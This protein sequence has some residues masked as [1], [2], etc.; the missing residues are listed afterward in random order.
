[1]KTNVLEKN[2]AFF[3]SELQSDIKRVAATKDE[4]IDAISAW[5]RGID[6]IESLSDSERWVPVSQKTGVLLDDLQKIVA[7]V[8][9]ITSRCAENDVRLADFLEDLKEIGVFGPEP[10][11]QEAAKNKLLALGKPLE[12]LLQKLVIKSS[13]ELPLLHVETFKV[14]C[15]F[16]SEFDQEFDPKKDSPTTYKPNLKYLHPRITLRISFHE[17]Q[18]P[19]GIL[20]SPENIRDFR[21]YLELAELQLAVASKMISQQKVVGAKE[22][23]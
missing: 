20:L 17:E 7:C 19:I 23:V 13:P 1:M 2:P 22:P 16:I 21:K 15:I 6:A 4:T 8:G 3:S 5:L 11:E 18:E 12:P 9:W 10:Q 14:R